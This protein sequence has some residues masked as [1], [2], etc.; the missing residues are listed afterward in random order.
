MMDRPPAST[1]DRITFG[2]YGDSLKH[3]RE[4]ERE[5]IVHVRYVYTSAVCTQRHPHLLGFLM[6]EDGQPRE[7][8]REKKRDVERERTLCVSE[9]D[10][11]RDCGSR[12]WRTR[13]DTA[14]SPFDSFH[15]FFGLSFYVTAEA[16]ERVCWG[17]PSDSFFSRIIIRSDGSIQNDD[18]H[19]AT[20]PIG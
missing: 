9:F 10:G 8:E 19:S 15:W 3:Q 5:Y 14:H 1:M 11:S 17:D 16:D 18:W 6:E 7:R 13:S 20:Y 4:R 12:T 2:R